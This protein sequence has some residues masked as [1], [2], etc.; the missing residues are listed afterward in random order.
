[1]KHKERD[2][3]MNIKTISNNKHGI[4]EIG[5]GGGLTCQSNSIGKSCR[6]HVEK[7]EIQILRN[8]S[9]AVYTVQLAVPV[10][11]KIVKWK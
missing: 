9:G 6:Y 3:D 4:I 11:S 1:M 7:I 5:E 2:L 10:E 8:N